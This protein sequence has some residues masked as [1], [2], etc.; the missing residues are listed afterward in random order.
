MDLGWVQFWN[1]VKDVSALI[2]SALVLF[3]AIRKRKAFGN[4]FIRS[5]VVKKGSRTGM[6]LR[7]HDKGLRGSLPGVDSGCVSDI[8]EE[9]RSSD[10]VTQGF[11]TALWG[12]DPYQV[13]VE[14]AAKGIPIEEITRR[15]EIPRGEIVLAVN[16]RKSMD[17]SVSWKSCLPG[18]A[19]DMAGRKNLPGA[20]EISERA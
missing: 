14:M 20:P 3:Y 12:A 5:R 15:I 11:E 13:A 1:T 4:S 17:R 19:T 6:P 18:F 2:L 9:G 10:G 7:F 16:F 8:S